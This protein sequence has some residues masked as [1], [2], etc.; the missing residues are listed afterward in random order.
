VA[1]VRIDGRA[2]TVRAIALDEAGSLV[3]VAR[4][5]AGRG[6]YL[7]FAGGHVED[8]DRDLEAALRRELDEEITARFSTC[9]IVAE[10]VTDVGGDQRHELF[11]VLDLEAY[12]FSGGAGP[13]WRRHDPD[14]RYEV[15]TRRLG[16][17]L[18]S[19]NLLP[20]A[21][22]E[23]LVAEGDPRLW[24]EFEPSLSLRGR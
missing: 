21:L 20:A 8:R 17:D 3:L 7:T 9:R 2:L 19:D 18:V 23:R 5:R 1:K 15:V 6:R 24:P 22:A 4:E 16:D 13:E 10:T 11:Y 12:S 14:N